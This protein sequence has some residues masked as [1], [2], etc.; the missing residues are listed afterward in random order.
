MPPCAWRGQF[1]NV[2]QKEEEKRDVKQSSPL[3]AI[4]NFSTPEVKEWQK[5]VKISRQAGSGVTIK[6]FS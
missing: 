1:S 2:N 4:Q 6:Q 3:I 5:G